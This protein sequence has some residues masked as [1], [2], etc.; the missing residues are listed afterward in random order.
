MLKEGWDVTNLYTIVPLNASRSQILTEQIIGRGLRLP[1][2]VRTGIKKI[3][4][5]TI[6]AHDSYQAIV[7]EANKP[8]SIIH[9]EQI[10]EIDPDELPTEQEVITVN[11]SLGE[12]ILEKQHQI[13]QLTDE[14]EKQKVGILL[15]AE[16]MILDVAQS[17][18]SEVKNINDLKSEEIKKIAIGKMLERIEVAP[19]QILFKDKMITDIEKEYQSVIND[20]IEKTIPIPRIL[21]Q[22][23]KEVEAIFHDFDLETDSLN[24]QPVSEELIRQFLRTNEREIIT[25]EGDNVVR[26]TPLNIIVNEL[27]NYPAIEYDKHSK[28]LYKLA[29]QAISKLNRGNDK[30]L[31]N[32]VLYHKREIAGFIYAQMDKHFELISSGFEKPIVYP[33]TKIESHNYTRSTADQIYLYTETITPTRAIPTKIFGGFKKSCHNLYKFDSKAEKDLAII[34]ENDTTVLRWLRPALAQFSLYWNHNTQRYIPDF[35]VETKEV[36]YLIEIKAENQINDAEVREKSDA[37]KVFCEAATNYNKANGGKEWKYV[38]IPHN[39]VAPNMSLSGL[40]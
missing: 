20:L 14:K 31:R 39:A 26:D 9:N 13:D 2:G 10:I 37:A 3:D 28:L 7:D 18:N 40:I 38:L 4:T 21:I 34:L 36:I 1:Y 22:Q 30:E 6:I 33:Y 24:Y 17:I 27:I 19:Q 25:S 12:A 16:K 32:I 23:A 8:D 29:G 15:E 35:V 11:S 5:L